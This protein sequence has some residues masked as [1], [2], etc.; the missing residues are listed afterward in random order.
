MLAVVC[1]LGTWEKRRV[2]ESHFDA[3]M[4]GWGQMMLIDGLGCN[5]SEIGSLALTCNMWNRWKFIKSAFKSNTL[6]LLNGS[7]Q[8][9]SRAIK[10]KR[11]F[12]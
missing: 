10:T 5:L 9:K 4:G 8:K 3:I 7:G 6:S 1:D 11:Q 12:R 2:G